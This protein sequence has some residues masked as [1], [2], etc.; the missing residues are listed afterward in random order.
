MLGRSEGL[1]SLHR[2]EEFSFYRPAGSHTLKPLMLHKQDFIHIQGK[3]T[4]RLGSE[5]EPL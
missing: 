1:F 5:V 3:S 2:L 4:F